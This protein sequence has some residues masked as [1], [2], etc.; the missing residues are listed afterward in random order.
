MRQSKDGQN[1]LQKTIWDR[2][3]DRR[4]VLAGIR[5]ECYTRFLENLE[6]LAG[7]PGFS[8]EVTEGLEQVVAGDFV[9][10]FAELAGQENCWPQEL[11][12]FDSFQMLLKK[13]P[14]SVLLVSSSAIYGKQY[15]GVRF[16][17]EDEIG[18]VCHTKQA[19]LALQCMRTSEHFACRFYR[20][21]GLPIKIV[22][23]GAWPGNGDFVAELL[24]KA[25]RVLVNGA[26]G[27]AYNLPEGCTDDSA[28]TNHCLGSET[29]ENRA[30]YSPL[31]AVPTYMDA[32]KAGKLGK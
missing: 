2:L 12:L 30:R 22:R 20:E 16:L 8:F 1:I 32:E 21:N 29:E 4:I 15:G 28:V 9:L 5:G 24:D 26:S 3:A 31:Q 7:Q 6:N 10:L 17:H 13:D 27:E 23:L 25:M 18:Y 11:E 14:A 19:E